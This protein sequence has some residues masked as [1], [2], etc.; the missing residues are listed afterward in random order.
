MWVEE[1]G[2]ARHR[3]PPPNPDCCIPPCLQAAPPDMAD[4]PRY[5]L[6]TKGV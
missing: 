2:D 6:V 1:M 4:M 3:G 5:K